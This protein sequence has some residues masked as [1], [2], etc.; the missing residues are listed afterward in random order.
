MVMMESLGM[1]YG[2]RCCCA[3]GAAKKS[4]ISTMALHG[5]PLVS[6]GKWNVPHVGTCS[7]W[8]KRLLQQSGITT[9]YLVNVSQERNVCRLG[10]MVLLMTIIGIV[11]QLR[12]THC[13]FLISKTT[14][15]PTIHPNQSIGVNCI[16]RDTI[17]ASRIFIISTRQETM[18]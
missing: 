12:P 1:S 9:G 5:I 14:L 17:M 16:G 10:S 8:G 18:R 11:R 6:K 15:T 13:L 2:Q 4:P 7:P 3:Q